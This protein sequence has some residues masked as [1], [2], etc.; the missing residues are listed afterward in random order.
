MQKKFGNDSIIKNDYV[1]D[2]K[3]AE[4]VYFS[5]LHWA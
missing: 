1:I 3:L 5:L 4:F 2:G